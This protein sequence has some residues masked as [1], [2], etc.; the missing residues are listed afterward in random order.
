M[1]DVAERKLWDKYMDAYEDMIR[2]TSTEDAPWYVVPAD[3]KQL[4]HLVVSAAIVEA[5]EDCKLAAPK[6]KETAE[7]KEVRQALLKEG[8]APAPEPNNRLFRR[9]GRGGNSVTLPVFVVEHHQQIEIADHRRR[10]GALLDAGAPRGIV[11]ALRG[12]L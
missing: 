3:N 1:G 7:L 8:G 10:A 2:E 9:L 4:A 6:V 11:A 12:F 5:M